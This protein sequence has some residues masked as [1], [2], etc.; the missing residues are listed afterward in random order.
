MRIK[1]FIILVVLIMTGCSTPFH[2]TVKLPPI[3]VHISD[4][5]S[6][7]RGLAWCDSAEICVEGYVEDGKIIPTDKVLGHEV[8]HIMHHVD[9]AIKY[10]D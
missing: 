4:D 6:G 8:I 10:P 2:H 1:L 7:R 3:T 5:C 9:K